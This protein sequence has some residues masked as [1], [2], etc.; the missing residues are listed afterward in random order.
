MTK[1]IIQITIVLLGVLMLFSA[2]R[3]DDWSDWTNGNVP[4]G[5]VS[6]R[7]GA[8][9]SDVSEVITRSV[10]P[11]G[12]GVNNMTLFCFDDYG[13]FITTVTAKLTSESMLKGSFT[14]IVPEN[15]KTIHFLANQNMASFAED[16][17]RN[18]SEAEVMA[19]LEGSSGMMIYW[20]RYAC[21]EGS[22]TD[23]KSITMVRNQAWVSIMNPTD[24]GFLEVT[25]FAAYNTNAFGTVAPYNPKESEGEERGFV[26]PGS[27]PFVTM[28][29][30][31][32]K[33]SDVNEVQTGED[34][35]IF[36]SENQLDDPVSIIIRGHAPGKSEELYYRVMLV[37]ENGEQILIRRNHHYMLNIKGELSFGQSTFEEAVKAAATNNVWI[38]IADNVTSVEDNDYILSVDKTDVVILGSDSERKRYELLYSI[39]G[40]AETVTDED[41]A[42][43]SWLEGNSVAAHEFE[44]EFN[45]STDNKWQ[46]KI[47]VI[48]NPM[49]GNE[50]LEGTLL[51][52]K[53]RL[54]RKIKVITVKTQQFTP[55]WA[56]TQIYGSQTNQHSHA[57]VM[58]TIPETCPA[59][60][61]PMRVLLSVVDLDV[62]AESG[63]Y[64]P[65]VREGEEGYGTYQP[66]WKYKYVY[67]ANAP[68][69]QRVYFEN[70]LEE[71]QGDS[72]PITI[73]ADFFETL[74]KQFTFA[75]SSDDTYHVISVDG[76]NKYTGGTPDD[77][78]A[79]DETILYRLVPQKRNAFVQFDLLTEVIKFKE[80]GNEI[81][82]ERTPENAGEKDEFLLYSSNL[83][84][85]PDEDDKPDGVDKFDCQFYPIDEK[86]YG[87]GGR[88]FMF[89][90]REPNNPSQGNTGH[91]SIYMR[92]NRAKSAE[93]VRIASNQVESASGL[94]ENGGAKYEGQTYRSATFE[95]AN[96]NPFRFSAQING[97]GTSTSDDAAEVVTPLSWSYVPSQPVN[98]EFDIT[99]FAGSD[100]KSVD[101][102]GTSFD[103]YID[104]PMLEI[105]EARLGNLVTKLKADPNVSGRFIYTVD[106]D[107]EEERKY[108][109]GTA[110]K[111]DDTDVTNPI[112]QSGERKS[113]PF[114]TKDIVSAGNI[115]ISSQEEEVVFFKKTF[116]V[117]NQSI[118]GTI[119][120]TD[121]EGQP[122]DVPAGSFVV[123]ERQLNGSRIG[124]MTVTNAGNYELR[125][126][127]EYE[128]NWN[129]DKVELSYTDNKFVYSCT[130]NSLAELFSNRDI[131]LTRAN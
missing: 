125:L 11:D 101:P 20:A 10:D 21:G 81:K 33:L 98:I 41:K 111:K 3:T 118:T 7:F 113:L 123:F 109:T 16:D 75:N 55:A 93:V 39:E 53:G 54:Q 106:A 119:K 61:F 42:E 48:L 47:T 108:G 92:T 96:Y 117:T 43:I 79:D 83:D 72:R 112:D 71:E 19:V 56:A 78:F 124:S 73:E 80:V 127:K 9:I 107:R 46:G 40:K 85:I 57:T 64:L 115:V 62:R 13:L 130:V 87:S 97:E 18:K 88:V 58:F 63:M 67:T 74:T 110:L 36:E 25:G 50:K 76:L 45:E 131:V 2:C 12:A 66:D 60:L 86:D 59:E 24:N 126:R 22:I 116:N 84:H 1:I 129:T 32:D 15:T 4:E 102:F 28:P 65:L 94:P 90:P 120:Y 26:W 14:A 121:G 44:H 31:T 29:L 82:E 5:Y 6:I 122:E 68:G 69:V 35:Y 104:A 105:D 51:V 38:S 114:R 70:V 103:I 37:D 8:E 100:G 17:F 128:F 52:K 30:N 77:E 23:L 91:Y 95:L 34:I 89:K 49:N 27:E 99:S